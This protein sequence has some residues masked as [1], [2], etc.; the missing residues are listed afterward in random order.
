MAQFRIP[1]HDKNSE[2]YSLD[3]RVRT[4]AQDALNKFYVIDSVDT[5]DFLFRDGQ[6]T[7]DKKDE[8]NWVPFKANCEYWGYREC[9][10]WFKQTVKVP[11]SFKGQ[12]VIYRIIPYEAGWKSERTGSNPQFKVFVNGKTTQGCDS[13][14]QYVTLSNCAEGGEVLEICINAYT[15]DH[16]WLGEVRMGAVLEAV[17]DVAF[18]FFYDVTTPLEVANNYGEDDA[19]RIDIIKALNTACNI[20][21]VDSDDREVFHKTAEEAMDYLDKNLYGKG[22]DATAWCVGHTHIDV[23]WLWRLR[24]TRD[25]AGRS[26][27]TVLKYMDEYPEYKFMSSQ[28][29]LYDYVKQDY[30]DVYEGI[31][32]KVKDGKWEVEGSMWVEADTN[33]SGGE[34]LVRQFLVGKRFFKQEFGVDNKIMWL[35]DVFGYSAA[36]PQLIKKSGMEYF[37]TTKI[38]WND[39]NKFPY[40]TFMWK[41]IDGTEVL[42]HFP[43]SKEVDYDESM[44]WDTTYNG[45]LNP[46][47]IM[48]GYKRYSQK[49]LSKEWLVSYGWGDGGGGPSIHMLEQGRRMAKGIPGCPVVKQAHSIDFF[50][51]L[52]SKV[53]DNPKLPK[54]SGELYLEFHRGTLTSM[55]RNKKYNR[56]SEIL[57]HDVETLS[58]IANKEVGFT[59]PKERLLE[60]WKVILTNQ[61]HDIL[62]GSSIKQVY[63]DSKV[64]YEEVLSN[65][66]EMAGNAQGALLSEMNLEKDSIVVFNTT[67][68]NRHDAVICDAPTNEEFALFD[69]N[70][71][72]V[73]Y[74]KTYDGKIVFVADVSPKGYSS[75]KVE[76]TKPTVKENVAANGKTVETQF[77]KAEFNE[78]YNISSLYHKES[79][80]DV[81]PKGEV[82]GKVIAFQDRPYCYPAWDIKSYYREKSWD[83]DLESAELIEV[84]P[85]RAVY[86]VNRKFRNSVLTQY[87]CFYNDLE[88]IDIDH[89][90]DWHENRVVLKA[91]YPVDVNATRATYDIQF[92]N[93]ERST[94]ENTTWEFAQFEVPMHKWCDLSDNGFGLSVINDCKYG[95][96]IK[97][98]RIRPT[99][100]RCAF[101][102][103][104]VQDNEFHSFT[105]SLYPHAK[106][107]NDS[108][109]YEEAFN[110]NY[111]LYAVTEKAHEGTLPSDYS[112]V[113]CSKNNVIV[114]TVKVAEDS[115]DLIVRCYECWN[116]KTNA[117]LTFNGKILSATECNLMEEDDTAIEF[118]DNTV[119]A[120][121]KPFEI[122][123]FK[124][125]FK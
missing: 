31:K 82:L 41:G 56:K 4:I 17:D 96:A 14:H 47:E 100:F 84:G 7:I 48:G 81:A 45:H 54:W 107:V 3:N 8:G 78:D 9:Y 26:F 90:S 70:G 86:K 83:F 22:M 72:E 67:G 114:E 59:Y 63:E 73:A 27:A 102:H 13:N 39:F 65:G 15:D 118:T 122:K 109:V 68:F 19:P 103:G 79:Q 77:Y 40:D 88:R 18:K 92:G 36:I 85:V 105:F 37:M 113:K 43:T 91:D 60:N 104:A 23:A 6:S 74:Q 29:Q 123:T 110:V 12:H 55:A 80:R 11:E 108:R 38:S 125:K 115:G 21:D 32:K 33:V 121:F 24:Q 76:L 51:D 71:N 50:K 64:Q 89:E 30:P 98:G 34:A 93:L 49:D 111:P 53:K 117:T 112:L 20:V 95:C 1:F 62:P 10:A 124:I 58:A 116:S 97:D 61:F 99:L 101:D 87:Y 120:T 35:P 52:E 44:S 66:C 57:Y 75:F 2:R 25:K 46:G 119:T 106:R 94:T 28:A 16:A 69:K 42:S 5:G